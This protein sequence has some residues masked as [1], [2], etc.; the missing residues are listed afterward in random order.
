MLKSGFTKQV[1]IGGLIGLTGVAVAVAAGLY[2]IP[3]V[4]IQLPP[5]ATFDLT[6]GEPYD[7]ATVFLFDNV[8][9][10]VDT[11]TSPIPSWV[12]DRFI[13]NFDNDT[14][15]L[16][17]DGRYVTEQKGESPA[18]DRGRYAYSLWIPW[19]AVDPGRHTLTVVGK[20]VYWT[21]VS[22][23]VHVN[24]VDL[25]LVS[26]GDPYTPQSDDTLESVARK[27]GL[28]P[29]MLGAANPNITSFRD[30]ISP[31]MPIS[32]PK[33]FEPV[34]TPPQDDVQVGENGYFPGGDSEPPE[35]PINKVALWVEL[36]LTKA[37]FIKDGP[38]VAPTLFRFKE[39]C[40]VTLYIR[41]NSNNE[42]GFY[43][44]RLNPGSTVFNRIATF[45][46]HSGDKFIEYT[47]KGLYGK[48]QYYASAF[49]AQGESV[50]SFMSAE[51]WDKGCL[52]PK[53]AAYKLNQVTLTPKVFA[54]KAYCYY[55]YQEGEWSR[56][57]EDPDAFV[58]PTSNGFDLSRPF[59]EL[60]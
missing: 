48:Y 12:E 39:T 36:G 17:L 25:A 16:Y 52:D 57:P 22:N 6:I 30:P 20:N 26:G 11:H 32:I 15:Y 4:D 8:N 44:Y 10:R 45:G 5:P 51:F 23:A 56:L 59:S 49:N 28:S 9:I 21:G 46:P 31:D 42:L 1:F 2:F 47:D 13:I 19:E 40:E 50:D 37:G 7:E 60:T 34:D 29:I 24:V 58:Y 14:Y 54:D 38:P 27:F 43:L 55:S 3:G 41:D 18:L 53:M 35:K 33:A